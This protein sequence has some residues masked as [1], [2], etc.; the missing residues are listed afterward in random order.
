M[1]PTRLPRL[2]LILLSGWLALAHSAAAAQDTSPPL[3]REIRLPVSVHFAM[4]VLGLS[5]LTETTGEASMT[6]EMTERWRDPSQAFDPKVTGF[7]RFDYVGADADARLRQMWT[8]GTEIENQISEPRSSSVSLSVRSDGTVTR[9]RRLDAD[10]RVDVDMQTFPFDQQQL[11]LSLV[12]PRHSADEVIFVMND[13]DREL[14]SVAK[15]LSASNWTARSLQFVMERFYGWNAKPFVRIRASTVVSRQWP[16]YL[17]PIFIPFVAVLS[18]SLFILWAPEK[19]LG[20]KAPMTYSALLALAALS[21]TYESSFPGSI[22]MNSPVAFMVSLG[23][24]Y[25]VL[26]LLLNIILVYSNFPGK[27]RFAHLEPA[28]R[29]NIRYSVP[30][31]FVLICVCSVARSLL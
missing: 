27:L 12:T 15:E 9:I 11:T 25:L 29:A 31:S 16:H 1:K 26:V 28:I 5:R 2:F 30:A 10:F 22:S 14:S 6:I 21:F 8:P 20:D 24:F 4:R 3:P 18:V 19:L 13:I 23:Y 7:G 17:L